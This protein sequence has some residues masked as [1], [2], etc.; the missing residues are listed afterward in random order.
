M[1]GTHRGTA[2]RLEMRATTKRRAQVARQGA[3]VG[4]FAANDIEREEWPFPCQQLE[5]LDRDRAGGALDHDALA[6]QLMEPPSLVVQ[7]RIHW[8]YLHDRTAKMPQHG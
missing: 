5:P 3:D 7:R 4:A 2:E 8:R 6:R 1:K